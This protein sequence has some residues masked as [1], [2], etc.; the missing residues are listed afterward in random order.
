VIMEWAA[1][2]P[3]QSGRNGLAA[4]CEGPDLHSTALGYR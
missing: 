2:P 3:G 4:R 1:V